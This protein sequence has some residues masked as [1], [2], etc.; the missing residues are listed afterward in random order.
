[1]HLI[2]RSLTF[3]KGLPFSL[4]HDVMIQTVVESSG[5]NGPFKEMVLESTNY[6]SQC[7]VEI[8]SN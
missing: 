4:G 5:G 2:W 6:F 7:V 8:L 1:M 3:Q